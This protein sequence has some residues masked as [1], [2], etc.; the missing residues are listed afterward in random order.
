MSDP[1]VL[2]TDKDE[3]NENF[4]VEKL[5]A[6]RYQPH[7]MAFYRVARA[8]DN[9][10]DDALLPPEEKLARL[11]CIDAALANEADTS[12]PIVNDL[13]QSLKETN[14]TVQHSRDLIHAFKQDV[15][16][17][18][19]NNWAELMDYC[20]YSAAPVGRYLLDLHGEPQTAWPANDALCAA[21]Q[22]INHIQDCGDD[23]RELDRVYIPLDMMAHFGAT[24][25]ELSNEKLSPA[26]RRTL[27]EMLNET[28]SLMLLAKTF[29]AQIRDWH[30]KVDT[31]VICEVADSLMKILSK[32]DPLC[33]N[34]KLG[35]AQKLMLLG[36]G[37]LKAFF[38]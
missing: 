35:K 7:V 29:P 9:I 16:K 23:Y 22:V 38:R 14:V 20:R 21:L 3:T 10:S 24:P 33:E 2:P 13:K 37:T 18:R 8:A 31:S 26:M 34:V 12:I 4:P 30:L 6:K 17:L 5:V 36:L 25:E 28:A 15:T 1:I 19:Y 32:R 11:D 27:D